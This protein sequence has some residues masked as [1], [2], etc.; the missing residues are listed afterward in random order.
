[1]K[2]LLLLAFH[3]FLLIQLAI[4]DDDLCTSQFE[5]T[6]S[7]LCAQLSTDEQTCFFID[8]EC[9]NWYKECSNYNPEGNFDESVCTRIQPSNKLTKC[10]VETTADG[11]KSCVETN[12]ACSDFTDKT[13]L[14][15]DLGTI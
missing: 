11:K 9:K 13:C 10:K 15:L 14:N 6:K 1:M 7:S 2:K 5:D 8:N 4:S 12:K 3:V